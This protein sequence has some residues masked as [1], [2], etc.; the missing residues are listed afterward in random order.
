MIYNTV[1]Q[2]AKETKSCINLCWLQVV[3]ELFQGGKFTIF[4]YTKRINPIMVTRCDGSIKGLRRH[5]SLLIYRLNHETPSVDVFF[6][7][8]FDFPP[9]KSSQ[10]LFPT[11]AEA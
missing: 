9:S 2:L 6:S 11:W 1:P 5:Q 8:P 10:I 7:F 4:C 3:N